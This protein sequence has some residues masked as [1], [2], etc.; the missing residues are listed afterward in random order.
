MAIGSP[1]RQTI[2]LS[3]TTDQP[4]TEPD[5]LLDARST[6]ALSQLQNGDLLK[7]V[8]DHEED[9]IEFGEH[10]K[11]VAPETL[12]GYFDAPRIKEFAFYRHPASGAVILIWTRFPATASTKNARVQHRVRRDLIWYAEKADI[13]NVATLEVQS[14]KDVTVERLIQ[15]VDSLTANK[16]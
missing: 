16:E 8:I 14:K 15:A 10:I 9:S 11:E 1:E 4:K 3:G 5:Y 2:S 13:K 12:A 6:E 7:L